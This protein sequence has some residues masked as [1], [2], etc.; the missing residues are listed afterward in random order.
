M[1][2]SYSPLAI[3]ASLLPCVLFSESS[4]SRRP[5]NDFG[6]ESFYRESVGNFYRVFFIIIENNTTLSLKQKDRN[7]P[8]TVQQ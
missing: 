8:G 7:H 5:E 3:T 1:M 2:V 6:L 4:E